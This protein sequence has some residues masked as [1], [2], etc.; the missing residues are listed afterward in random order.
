MRNNFANKVAVILQD[1]QS[2]IDSILIRHRCFINAI[3]ST[4]IERLVE[5]ISLY[6][7]EN[8]MAMLPEIVVP[9]FSLVPE[10]NMAV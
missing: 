10:K 8:L 2:L 6:Q 5:Y 1:K 3:R 4:E 7:T 9:P